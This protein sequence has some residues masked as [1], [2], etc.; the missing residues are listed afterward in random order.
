MI[1]PSLQLLHLDLLMSLIRVTK[2]TP[3]PLALTKSAEAS[4][5]QSAV[6]SPAISRS[7]PSSLCCWQMAPTTAQTTIPPVTD[8]NPRS[9]LVATSGQQAPPK[10]D[11]HLLRLATDSSFIDLE[12]HLNG[13]TSPSPYV[14]TVEGDTLLH[15]VA[16][17]G[18][19]YVYEK[20]KIC[21]HK[22]LCSLQ[23]DLTSK[24]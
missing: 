5:P 19:D 1:D 6:R 16:T 11:A 20:H 8:P 12:K 14:V 22:H 13:Q 9:A 23:V 17:F 7:T 2:S 18:D 3:L 21:V 24:Q 15:L 10:R 4:R